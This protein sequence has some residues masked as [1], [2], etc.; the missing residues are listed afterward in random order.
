[1]HAYY[2]FFVNCFPQGML[3]LLGLELLALLYLM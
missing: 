2:L 3:S 1:M